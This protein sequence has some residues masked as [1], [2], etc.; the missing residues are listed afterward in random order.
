MN[1]DKLLE[2]THY[3]GQVMQRLLICSI[4]DCNTKCYS[5]NYCRLHYARRDKLIF[6]YYLIQL[7]WCEKPVRKGCIT[8]AEHHI[9]SIDGCEKIAKTIETQLCPTHVQKVWTD[10]VP[11]RRE[12]T[13]AKAR[14][15]RRPDDL[16][17]TRH[18]K[19]VVGYFQAH[20]RVKHSKGGSAKQFDCIDC[21]NPG[22]HWS[23]NNDAPIVYEQYLE[24]RGITV[25]Y[26]LDPDMYDSRCTVCHKTYDRDTQITGEV[27]QYNG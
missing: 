25:H 26:S 21:G 15:Y 24:V 10:S 16:G 3:R 1:R 8:C 5:R 13:N 2:R 17:P 9:C 19:E 22:M 7:C 27:R 12:K 6:E 18:L 23:L 4:P 11:G 14:Q 20:K